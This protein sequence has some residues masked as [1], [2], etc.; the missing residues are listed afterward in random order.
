MA[1]ALIAT[2]MLLGGLVWAFISFAAGAAHPT[3][4]PPA[5]VTYSLVVGIVIALV[6]LLIWI[7]LA[8]TWS[9]GA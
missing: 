6:G 2:A 5:Y 4:D 1:E 7:G 9:T 3:G 8:F